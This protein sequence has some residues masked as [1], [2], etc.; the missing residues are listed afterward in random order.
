MSSFR[1]SVPL[2]AFTTIQQARVLRKLSRYP[3]LTHIVTQIRK[4]TDG[5]GG[6]DQ[7]LSPA[8]FRKTVSSSVKKSRVARPFPLRRIFTRR[9]S[10]FQKRIQST[11]HCRDG[12]SGAEALTASGGEGASIARMYIRALAGGIPLTPMPPAGGTFGQACRKPSPLQEGLATVS[13]FLHA[14]WTCCFFY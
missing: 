8:F 4:N 1:S 9:R 11:Y 6:A 14:K 7:T 3:G 10:Y 2:R 12:P 13:K 5:T